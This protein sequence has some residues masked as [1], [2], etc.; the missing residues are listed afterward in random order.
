MGSISDIEGAGS[1]IEWADISPIEVAPL[2][3]YTEEL[4]DSLVNG[5]SADKT[6]FD[7]TFYEEW[8]KL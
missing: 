1:S 5:Y 6:K 8:N 4:L 7:S 3:T 2:K